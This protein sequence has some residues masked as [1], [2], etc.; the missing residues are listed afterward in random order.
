MTGGLDELLNKT[1][2]NADDTR[3]EEFASYSSDRPYLTKIGA[4]ERS[5]T[6]ADV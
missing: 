1:G 3:A 4:K 6:D 2:M 5:Q